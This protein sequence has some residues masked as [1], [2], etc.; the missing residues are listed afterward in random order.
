GASLHQA[1]FT[2]AAASPSADK[3]V[4]DGAVMLARTIVGL[5]ESPEQ[6]ERVLAALE[7]RAAS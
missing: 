7:K 1:A 5:A 2:A 3:A 4:L 6:R